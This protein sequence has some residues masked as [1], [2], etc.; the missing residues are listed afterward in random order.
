MRLPAVLIL[1]CTIAFAVVVFQASSWVDAA[2]GLG[3]LV[4]PLT[5]VPC[6]L[7]STWSQHGP[8]DRVD[9]PSLT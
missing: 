4:A 1:L 6:S 5:V 9:N 8:A 7:L 2:N 3:Y